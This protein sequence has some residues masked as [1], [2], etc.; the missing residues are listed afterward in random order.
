MLTAEGEGEEDWVLSDG[1][2]YYDEESSDGEL[3]WDPDRERLLRSMRQQQTGTAP[4]SSGS[5]STLL[6]AGRAGNPFAPPEDGHRILGDARLGM[7][8]RGTDRRG[9][10]VYYE[11]DGSFRS[12]RPSLC[13]KIVPDVNLAD[14]MAS[15]PPPT[16]Y[17]LSPR[18]GRRAGSAT[19]LDQ[20]N[21]L[22]LLP[23]PRTYEPLPAVPRREDLPWPINRSHT[24]PDTP[25]ENDR[26]P[27]DFPPKYKAPPS[28]MR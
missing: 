2:S 3:D 7:T 13:A 4:S 11:R 8:S 5:S 25:R 12:T 23:P 27:L 16:A 19:P 22:A 15:L 1:D 14:W 6:S 24:R 17:D 9:R 20:P 26:H 28:W 21:P 18:R 10:S